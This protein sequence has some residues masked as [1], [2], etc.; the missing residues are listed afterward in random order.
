MLFIYVFLK[1]F[2]FTLF[3]FTILY[4]FCHTLAWIR[5]GC[6][7]VPKHEPPSHLPP[8]ISL[9]HPRAPAPSILY[10]A[11][12]INWRFVSYMIVYII[13]K[14]VRLSLVILFF[15]LSGSLWS[16]YSNSPWTLEEP[17]ETLSYLNIHHLKRYPLHTA[18]EIIHTFVE[19]F[20]KMCIIKNSFQKPFILVQ[21]FYARKENNY[22]VKLW[23]KYDVIYL[24]TKY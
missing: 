11:S 1:I 6:T 3:Y 20:L 24:F 10:P 15:S 19:D 16:N 13:L 23:H 8:H 17:I 9:G 12:N 21:K 22:L 14:N 18:L 5:H 7:W 4:W 2:I